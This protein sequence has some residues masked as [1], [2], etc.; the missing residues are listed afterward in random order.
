MKTT[1]IITSTLFIAAVS[2]AQ[3]FAHATFVDG[4]AEQESTV[5]AALQVPHGCEGE[6]A[7]T[8][9]QIKLP[10]GFISAKPQP[11]VGWELEVIKGD[12]QKAYKNHGKEIKSGPV[13]IRWKGG[14]LPDE[15]YDTFA[16]QGKV[17]GVEV[18]QELPFKV[19][20]LCGDKGKV[21]WDEV[22]AAGVDPH[23]LKN[24]APTIKVT[25]NAHAGGHDHAGM[26]MDMDVVKAGNLEVSGGATKAML[27]GQPVGGGYVTIMNGGD[28]DDKLIAVESSAAGRAEIHE[29]AMVN[30]VMKMRK[31]DEGIVIPAGQTV[32]LKPGGLHM[33]FF[34][35]KKPFAEGDKVPVTLIFEK[36]GKVDVILSAGAAKGGGDHQHN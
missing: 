10:E 24:P 30:D 29:M 36:A 13:E 11:K 16:V 21:S 18:G 33:M 31:L 20:Q 35:V 23:S 12:Y 14:N 15:F 1:K 26:S 6:L 2:T 27:P 19:T 17:S 3:A 28:S 7:T 22:A 5:V 32:E 34:D 4:S 8:E 25:A 9:V